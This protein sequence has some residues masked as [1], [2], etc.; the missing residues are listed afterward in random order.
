MSLRI[1]TNIA[2]VAAQSQVRRTAR[3]VEDNLKQMA[4]GSRFSSPSEA[5]GDF[6]IAEQLRAQSSG[7]EASQRNIQSAQS[8]SQIAEGALN[9]QSN[10][11]IRLKELA[12]QASSSTGD[13]KLRS[14]SQIEFE[15]MVA[16]LDRI[17][18]TTAY[19]SHRFLAGNAKKYDFQVG[20]MDSSHDRISVNIGSNTTASEL[21]IDGLSLSSV[22]SAR[23]ALSAID[24]A[25]GNI[26][27]ARAAFGALQSR[28]S[29]TLNHNEGMV[30]GLT[31]ARSNIADA[32]FAKV[33][34]EYYRNRALQQYQ[35]AAL[36][37]A[38]HTPMAALKLI[39]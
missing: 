27:N 18:Q 10:I 13:E 35:M 17:A 7:Y 25:F 34:S 30:E 21:D 1:H 9:E 5:P 8:F 6:A 22:R 3:T 33:T 26:A 36:A 37:E 15:Q 23:K 32:D 24:E 19:G 16:E 11:L 20:P 38:N 12:M 39:A 28:M 4:S 2:S 29:S 14:L 31:A